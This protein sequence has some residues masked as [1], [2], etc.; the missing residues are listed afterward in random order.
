MGFF[1]LEKLSIEGQSLH[2]KLRVISLAVFV[3]PFTIM[4]YILYQQGFF[5]SLEPLHRIIFLFIA[6]LAFAGIMV[7]RRHSTSS[8]WDPSS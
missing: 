2:G 1:G 8:S 7:L 6:V 3:F 5:S 4:L